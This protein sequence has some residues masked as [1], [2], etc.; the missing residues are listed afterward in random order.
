MRCKTISGALKCAFIHF[1]TATLVVRAYLLEERATLLPKAE[2]HTLW[3]LQSLFA[4][5]KPHRTVALPDHI[6]NGEAGRKLARRWN[7]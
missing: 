3:E 2:R 6:F 5:G 4:I 7:G 1:H